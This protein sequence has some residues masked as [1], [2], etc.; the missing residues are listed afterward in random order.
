[1]ND[2]V[3]YLINMSFEVNQFL[4]YQELKITKFLKLIF[5]KNK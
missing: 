4:I 3:H 2:N 1:M 5:H